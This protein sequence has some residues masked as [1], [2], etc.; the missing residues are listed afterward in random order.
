[1]LRKIGRTIKDIF[2]IGKLRKQLLL[3]RAEASA[4][5]SDPD[6][7]FIKA[8]SRGMYTDPA[9]SDFGKR[10]SYVA[11]AANFHEAILG[12]KIIAKIA[13]VRARL[14]KIDNPRELDHQLKGTINGLWVIYDW[15]EEM[16]S[17]HMS[18]QQKESVNS[19]FTEEEEQLLDD[20]GL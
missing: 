4:H 12:P 17:E 1:M 20:I 10:K 16:K 7:P 2:Q 19:I 18:Y 6:R 13:E 9:P 8:Q 15:G 5:R 3:A 14:E 11:Q